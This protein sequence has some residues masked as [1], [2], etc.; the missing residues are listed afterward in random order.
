M[1][2]PATDVL[3]D[4]FLAAQRTFGE[5]VHAV[6]DDRWSAGTPCTEWSVAQLVG[7]L[8]EE[9]RW[10]APLLHGHD[11]D[12]AGK[13]VAGARSLPVDGGVGA[14]RAEEWDEAATEAADAASADGALSRTVTL[15]RGASPAKDYLAELTVDHVVHSWDLQ[16]AIG[17]GSD[18]PGELVEFAYGMLRDVGDMSGSGVF[19]A[20]VDVPGDAPLVDRLVAL[21]GRD[22]S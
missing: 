18:L 19:A 9:N 1:E 6:G 11:L 20:P 7:H 21:T 17:F 22:P 15:S 2:L 16:R 10:V 3:L 8:I 4:L 12:S 13:I 5:R 14:D